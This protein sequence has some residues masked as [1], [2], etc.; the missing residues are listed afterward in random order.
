M[1]SK[2]VLV[3]TGVMIGLFILVLLFFSLRLMQLQVVEGESLTAQIEQGWTD[4]QTIKAARG[5]I[6]DRNGQPLAV[7]AVG[8]DVVINMAYMGDTPVNEVIQR[9]IGVMEQAGEGWIDNLP[10]TQQAPFRFLDEEAYATQIDRLKRAVDAQPY[11]TAEDVCALLREKYGLE[12]LDDTRFRQVAGVR[13]EMEQRGF[14]MRT[15]YTFATNI[16]METVPQIKEQGYRLPGVDVVETPIRQYVSGDIAPHL[17]GQV[18]PLYAEQWNAAE[19]EMTPDGNVVAHIGDH[20]YLMNDSIGIS[21]VEQAFESYLRGQDGQRVIVR[22]NRGDVIDVV[23]E[24]PAVPGDSVV[25]T[26]DAQLQ[27]VAQDALANKIH[28]MQQDLVTYPEGEGHEVDA[29]AVVVLDVKTGELLAAATYPSYNLATYQQDYAQ[30]ASATPEPLFNRALSASYRP[31]STFKPAVALASLAEGVI[32]RDTTVLC[33]GQYTRFDDYQPMCEGVHGLVNVLGAINS[34]CNLFFYDVGYNLGIEKIDEYAHLLGLGVSSGLELPENPG[35]VASPELKSQ[36]HTG[37][38][39]EWRPG[40]VIQAAIGQGDTMLS[41][42]QLAN[43]TATLANGGQRM[44]VT[45]LKSVR[46]YNLEQ[47][48]YDHEPQ[49]AASIDAPEALEA[50]KE[51][52]VSVARQG[53]ARGTFASYPLDVAAKTGS[54]QTPQGINSVFIAYAPADDP[55]I[56]VAVVLEKGWEGYTGAPVAKEIFDAYFFSDS[57]K[58]AQPVDYGVLLS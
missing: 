45:I 8:R 40:D 56:A 14:N 52:M 38:E 34:S 4:T 23:E 41:P 12:E 47:A 31:G 43:Y 30:L 49:V 25:L 51:G 22:N 53:T 29:G 36:L 50:V 21:G 6:F 39:V 57:S 27:K 18:G 20:T 5:Q 42:L 16:R 24:Q 3:R 58:N 55:E 2:W 28:S 33:T 1:K 37:E 54:P 19:K 15:P 44:E 32:D 13:Y 46:S 17:I 11:A 7:N 9:L 26:I 10:I 48:V 35:Q